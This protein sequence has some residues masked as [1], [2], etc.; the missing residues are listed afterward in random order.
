MKLLT[1]WINF[2]KTYLSN[3]FKPVVRSSVRLFVRPA[4]ARKE[5][6]VGGLNFLV[7]V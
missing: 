5:H 1:K 3:S 6:P 2:F 4:L 7:P